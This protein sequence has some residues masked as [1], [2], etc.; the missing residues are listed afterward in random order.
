MIFISDPFLSTTGQKMK[1]IA[2]LIFLCVF[3]LGC[4]ISVNLTPTP[5]IETITEVVSTEPLLVVTTEAPLPVITEAPTEAPVAPVFNGTE[6]NL[7]GV[8]MVLPACLAASVGSNI[9][10]AV[11]YDGGPAEYYPTNRKI[12]F[13][14]Y[15][16]SGK[17][18]S[19]DDPNRT[20]GLVIYPVA[21][22]E[23]MNTDYPVISDRVTLMQTL[24]ATQPVAP[25]SI[26]LLPVFNA[27]SMFKA[28]VK[29]MNFLNGSGVRY[30]TEY[31][32]YYAPVNNTDLFYSFQ[33][34]T[35]DGKYWIS[36]IFPVNAAFLQESPDS[37]T[38]PAGGIAAPAYNDPNLDASMQ[39]YYTNMINL[40]NTT[41]DTQFTPGLD[42]LDQ[43]VQSLQIGD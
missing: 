14:G 10:A 43:F 21:E 25:E 13:Q 4:S 28:Q 35:A 17:F 11:P 40:L 22:F 33:G 23:A 19:V 37:T 42:C 20:G 39:A 5:A 7:S 1:K 30:L 27:A 15:L 36:G 34:L 9:I 6:Y 16:L 18:F 29:Y 41:P 31:S 26:P 32:Q 24:I 3:T 12:T 38:I 2:I 8:S